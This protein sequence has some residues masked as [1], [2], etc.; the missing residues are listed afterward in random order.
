MEVKLHITHFSGLLRAANSHS[1]TV[2]VLKLEYDLLKVSQ[3]S[4]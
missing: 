2:S 1:L 3:F 4:L